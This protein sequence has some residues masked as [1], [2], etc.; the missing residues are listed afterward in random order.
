MGTLPSGP[1]SG[2]SSIHNHPEL[3]DIDGFNYLSSLLEGPA[4]N[5][6]SGLRG[7]IILKQWLYYRA[8]SETIRR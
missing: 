3:T 8:G 5:S 2:E 4:A 1:L 7:P 6:V